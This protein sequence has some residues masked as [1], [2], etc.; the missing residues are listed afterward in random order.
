MTQLPYVIAEGDTTNADKIRINFESISNF[1]NNPIIIPTST[2]AD[3]SNSTLYYSSTQ[4]KL[5]WKD[6]SGTVHVL[7]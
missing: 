3:A 2:D 1:L 6:S 7:Y 4:G 5:V